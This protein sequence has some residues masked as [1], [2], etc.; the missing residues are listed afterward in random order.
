MTGFLDKLFKG[1]TNSPNHIADNSV[2]LA[3]DNVY[4]ALDA[5]RKILNREQSVHLNTGAAELLVT[6]DYKY[7]ILKNVA[8]VRMQESELINGLDF[9]IV[10]KS[11]GEATLISGVDS[12]NLPP[13]SVTHFL[14]TAEGVILLN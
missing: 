14:Q 12:I 6:S 9:F 7:V 1:L 4:D 5:V 3:L 10:N 13:N 11:V 2:R 8:I